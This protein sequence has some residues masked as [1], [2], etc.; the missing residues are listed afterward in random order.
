MPDT[1]LRYLTRERDRLDQALAA[2]RSA[3]VP[4]VSEIAELQQQRRIVDDQ[5][6]RWTADLA[7]VVTAA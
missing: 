7:E 5:L 6:E 3:E 4:D 1:F 2:A